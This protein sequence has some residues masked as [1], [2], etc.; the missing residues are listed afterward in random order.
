MTLKRT[1]GIMLVFVLLFSLAACANNNTSDQT[2]TSTESATTA[3]AASSAT[4]AENTTIGKK[5]IVTFFDI[6]LPNDRMQI[7]FHTPI[8]NPESKQLSKWV[9]KGRKTRW[10]ARHGGSRS[11]A[12]RLTELFCL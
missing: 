10:S 4:S 3:S 1:L 5:S 8:I 2:Q 7:S 12:E 9:G 6:K 11:C